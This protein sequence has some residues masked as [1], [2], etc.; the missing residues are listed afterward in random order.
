M[1]STHRP[2]RGSRAV[3][4]GGG[5]ATGIAWEVGLLIGLLDAG[6]DLARADAI[7]G[8]SAGSFAGTH[9]ASPSSLSEHYEQQFSLDAFEISVTMSSEIRQEW[10][11]AIAQGNG[12]ARLIAKGLGAL[13]LRA[14]TISP[15]DRLRVVAGRLGRETWPTGPLTMTAVDA[16][17]GELVV[18]DKNSGVP[19]VTAAA[20]SGSVPGVW[21]Y[22]EA[23]GRKFIDGGVCSPAN[24]FLAA[25]FERI[26]VIA[27]TTRGMDGRNIVGEEIDALRGHSQVA[28]IEP[29]DDT[30]AAIGGNVFDPTVR[31]PVAEAGRRQG[32]AVADA[33]RDL[34]MASAEGESEAP[35]TPA[36]PSA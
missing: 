19:L 10:A 17:S 33:I 21:P 23:L 25:S 9:L 35:V 22:V 18:F 34:W 7:F 16:E 3:V 28:L 31:G 20:A 14:V 2:S 26:V 29:D 36:P 8:T 5:G 30:R 13:A 27:P 6:V 4:L 15:H 1:E 12:D 11:D 24:A 32:Q